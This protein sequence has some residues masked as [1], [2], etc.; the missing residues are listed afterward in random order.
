MATRQNLEKLKEQS[1]DAFYN[2]TSL[3]HV[4]LTS[5]NQKMTHR[6]TAF[7]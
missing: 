4:I 3:K 6:M 5:Q 7:I 2:M 1:T